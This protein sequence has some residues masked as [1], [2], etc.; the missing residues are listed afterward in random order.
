MD[1]QLPSISNRDKRLLKICN[2]L[3][4]GFHVTI[5]DIKILEFDQGRVSDIYRIIFKNDEKPLV[6]DKNHRIPIQQLVIKLFRPHTPYD[7]YESKMNSLIAGFERLGPQIYLTGDDYIAMEYID[8]KAFNR[9]NDYDE[10]FIQLL[11]SR[12]AR[13]HSLQVPIAKNSHKDRYRYIFEEW[14]DEKFWNQFYNESSFGMKALRENKCHTI[15]DYNVQI[16]CEFLRKQIE[17]ID[18]IIVFCHQD[19][20]HSNIFIINKQQPDIKFIDFDYSG[21]NLRGMDIGRYFA[22]CEKFEQYSDEGIIND[23]KMLRFIRYYLDENCNIYGPNY[24]QDPCNSPNTLLRESKVFVL[25]AQMIDIL[26]CLWETIAEPKRR[27]KYC[28]WAESRYKEYR[29]FK[30]RIANDDVFR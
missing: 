5:D 24:R 30:E 3:S 13:F 7:P 9:Q 18:P 20:N 23:E 17:A 28:L 26:F 12:L 15:I 4:I 25:F 10:K 22:D 1:N 21:Y 16:E 2:Q 14:A 6:Y 29:Q 8:A 19:L 11:A 27:D